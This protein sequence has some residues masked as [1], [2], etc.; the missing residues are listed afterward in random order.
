MMKD[1]RRYGSHLVTAI[2][3]LAA[4]MSVQGA[5]ARALTSDDLFDPNTI[6]EL[7]L[8]MN[9]HDLADMKAHFK[10]NTHYAAMLQWRDLRVWNVAVRMRGAGSRTP[11]KPPLV[12]DFARYATRQRFLGLSSIA[13]DNH[14]QDP[15]MFRERTAM[16]VF[17]RMGQPA[18]R[19][20]TTRVYINDVYYGI[21][22]VI[23]NVDISFL[24][25]SFGDVIG[26][27]NPGGFLHEY[28]NLRPYYFD[29]L[30]DSLTPYKELFEARTRTTE[31]DTTLYSPLRSL[32][33]EA[34]GPYDAVWR[35]RV[36]QY[37]DLRQLVTYVAIENFLTEWDGF[38]GAW[39]MNNF[40]LYRPADSMRFRIIPWDSDM[41]FTSVDASIFERKDQNVLFSRAIAFSDLR[42][43]YLDTL[44]QCA[45]SALQDH[46]LE[47]Y[48]T[49]VAAMVVDAM[50]ADPVKQWSNAFSD[51]DTANVLAIARDRSNFILSA[52]ADA[53]L[54]PA[55][56]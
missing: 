33:T 18:P 49:A 48:T 32:V 52:V 2:V 46:W 40:Y 31:A 19:E 10:D 36:E 13:L 50:H 6:Q 54:A 38:T 14:W 43:L 41:T 4:V 27:T 21:F 28:H 24:A 23:E 29:S 5:P 22:T 8:K 17:N 25:R 45:K 44:E 42:T 26:R 7:R 30:G 55:A 39:G 1:M 9:V 53:R 11:I 47:N 16:A 34:N 3:L 20:A 12:I 37:I 56:R 15:S 51:Q 35:S